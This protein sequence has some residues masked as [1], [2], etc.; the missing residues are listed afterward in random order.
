METVSI[1]NYHPN[2]IQRLKQILDEK[3]QNVSFDSIKTKNLTQIEI[4]KSRLN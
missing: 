3:V 1:A 4:E 2:N